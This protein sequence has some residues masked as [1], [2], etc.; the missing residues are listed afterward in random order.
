M[1]CKNDVAMGHK[2]DASF[3]INFETNVFC[4]YGKRKDNTK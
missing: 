4:L 2:G 1:Y 3:S